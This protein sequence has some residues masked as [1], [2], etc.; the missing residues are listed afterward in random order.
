MSS[1]G[2]TEDCLGWAARDPSG[3]LSPYKFSRRAV[4][5]DDVYVKITHC[6]VCYADVIWTRNHHHDSKYPLVPGHEIA[7]I[8]T[9][10]GS[11]VH[12]FNVGDHVGVGTYVNS[13]R[14]CEFCNDQVEVNCVKGS[15][16]TFNGVDFDGTITK[17]G[18]SSHIVVH[19]RYCF[20]IPK[21]YPLASAAPLLCAG[22]T[23]YS[24]MIRHKMNQPG[25]SLGVIGLGGLGHM[26]VKFGKAFGL[27]VT[28]LSSSIS[29]KEEAL[30]LLGADKFVLS[31]DPEQMKASAK[32]LDF[33]IDTASGDHPF[34]PYM[35]LLKTY[36]VFVLVGF[37]SVIKFGPANLNIGMKTLSGSI[38][39]GTKDIQEMINFCAE[40]EIYPNIEVIPIEYANEALERVVNKDV[41]Y[42]FV[43]DIEN[44][45]KA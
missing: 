41:K 11:N 16:F 37:P 17:G 32:S 33:I 40:K 31:S 12:R 22:I 39:G 21:S 34:D 30:T 44:S 35:S 18:Y 2:V 28:I 10:V 7:G 29:K 19:E 45:L 9:K 27:N 8:V 38:T 26:A 15:V 3:V 43:I 20:V 24:P 36:G 14:D 23:V 6:G 5:D 1:E 13:C 25:K 4:G 42:R